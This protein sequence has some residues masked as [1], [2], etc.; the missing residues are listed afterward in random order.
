MKYTPK[1]Y[2]FLLLGIP[3]L[4][5]SCQEELPTDHSVAFQELLDKNVFPR[6]LPPGL[7]VHIEAPRYGISWAG[8]AGVSKTDTD[9]K[10]NINP[11]L[12]LAFFC[13]MKKITSP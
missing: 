3:L 1:I 8:V 2:A 11:L 6:S 7:G 9:Q 13:Y 12:R 5:S 10:V 4:L